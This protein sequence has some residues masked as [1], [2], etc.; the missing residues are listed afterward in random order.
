MLT[1][2]STASAQTY[3]IDRQECSFSVGRATRVWWVTWREG[4]RDSLVSVFVRRSFAVLTDGG[5]VDVSLD[6]VK[7]R[8]GLRRAKL[9]ISEKTPADSLW[10]HYQYVD[11]VH[12]NVPADSTAGEPGTDGFHQYWKPESIRTETPTGDSTYRVSQWYAPF[13]GVNHDQS[14][15][16]VNDSTFVTVAF[17]KIVGDPTLHYGWDQRALIRIQSRAYEP[18]ELDSLMLLP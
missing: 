10:V 7:G 18:Q 6:S 11:S 5:R 16:T 1:G 14:T 4:L 2:I 13:D 3:Q 15:W 17:V 8:G 12:W 9:T